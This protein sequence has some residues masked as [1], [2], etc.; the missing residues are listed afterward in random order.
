MVLPLGQRAK[1]ARGISPPSLLARFIQYY[2]VV[3][4]T[5]LGKSENKVQIH[6]LHPMRFHIFQ[7]ICG[8]QPFLIFYHL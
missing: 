1:N 7:D 8:I 5:S 6:H 2:L 3:I 4:A